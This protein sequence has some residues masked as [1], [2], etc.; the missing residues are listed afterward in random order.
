MQTLLFLAS[1]RY[2]TNFYILVSGQMLHLATWCKYLEPPVAV[3]VKKKL[4]LATSTALATRVATC[5][6]LFA[7]YCYILE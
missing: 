3:G 7:V 5:V 4:L 2:I 6:V 1:S